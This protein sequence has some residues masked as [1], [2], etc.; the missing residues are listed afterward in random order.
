MFY[1]LG[2]IVLVLFCCFINFR[3]NISLA[4][5]LLTLIVVITLIMMLEI[6]SNEK[7]INC[8]FTSLQIGTLNADFPSIIALVEKKSLAFKICFY[9]LVV[10]TPLMFGGFI[11]SFF[12][13]AVQVA[14]FKVLRRRSDIYCF[15]ELNEH[16]LMLADSICEANKKAVIVFYNYDDKEELKN[17][18]RRSYYFVLKN[19]F[20]S[21]IFKSKHDIYY[22]FI[23][24]FEDDGSNNISDGLELLNACKN[25]K[26][27][28]SLL[29][30]KMFIFSE[31][32][33][34]EDILNST[35]KKGF[36]VTLLNKNEVIV[37]NLIFDYPFYNNMGNQKEIAV[38][39]TGSNK[40]AL[41]IA[42]SAVWACQFGSEYKISVTVIDENASDVQRQLEYECPEYF[43]PKWNYKLKFYNANIQSKEFDQILNEHCRNTTYAAVCVDD[44]S[45]SI[46][47]AVYLRRF[48]IRTDSDFKKE[49]FIAAFVTSK[50]K[51]KAVQELTAVNKEKISLKG[52]DIYS[53][54]SENYN[55]V[56][57]GYDDDIYSYENIVENKTIQLA[58]N[59]HA[60]YQYMFGDGS[61]I[62][63]EKL[64][65][66]F[67]YN[68][69]DKKS[70][71]AN[72]IHLKYKLHLLGY[73]L[74][75]ENEANSEEI[76]NA[77]IILKEIHEKLENPENM[78]YLARLEHDRWTAFQ[79]SQGWRSVSIEEAR[80]YSAVTGSHKHLKAK[81][82]P[83]ICT[84]EELDEIIKVFDPHL[85]DYD[86]EFVKKLPEILGLEESIVNVTNK[87]FICTKSNK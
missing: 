38:L 69:I 77:Q 46:Q 18:A 3:K 17:R 60:A 11:A 62:P 87:K 79:S 40:I 51:F 13:N 22:F 67:N 52:W 47:T 14:T 61:V 6:V 48:F 30:M 70:N 66:S 29:N 43:N 64:M 1:F 86:V 83:C 34:A 33:D 68:E 37:N 63:K 81:L 58:L 21:V 57:F 15:S 39:I 23:K 28:T 65:E 9:F 25:N 26:K 82:H 31:E 84:Y 7:F 10:L 4:L 35:D 8:F 42:R 76:E 32:S 45:L 56:P 72:G 19:G 27:I 24:E 41:E 44:D 50:E 2:L 20:D 71:R 36:M 16:S 55:I 74:K 85:K 5:K 54:K 73:E 12:D 53:P 49:P 59:C 78:D 80:N 75:A